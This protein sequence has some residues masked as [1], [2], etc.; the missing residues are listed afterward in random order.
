MK[1][2]TRQ[3]PQIEMRFEG[4]AVPGRISVDLLGTLPW[5]LQASLRRMLSNRRQQVGRFRGSVE[6]VCKLELIAFQPGSAV[7]LF[8]FAGPRDASTLQ[9][10]QGVKVAEEMFAALEAGESG[11]EDWSNSLHPGVREGFDNLTRNLG[12]GIDSIQLRLRHDG[13]ERAVRVT[14]AFRRHFGKRTRPLRLVGEVSVEGV[15]W[16]IDWKDRTAELY[17]ADGSK[18]KLSFTPELEERITKASKRRVLV[19]GLRK[20]TG[21]RVR[22]LAVA[23]LEQAEQSSEQPDP[24]YGGFWDNLSADELARRQG[25]KPVENLDDLKGDWPEGES[26]DEFLDLVREVRGR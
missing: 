9:G 25:V 20:G 19:R 10:D 21:D 15:V 22:E 11:T 3:P 13:G 4:P 17:E 16:E 23:D 5:E 6:Q 24:R 1:K 7:M 12:E 26:V 2:P 8:E 18:V 14:T